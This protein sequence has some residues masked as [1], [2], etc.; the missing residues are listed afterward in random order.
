MIESDGKASKP[1]AQSAVSGALYLGLSQFLRLFFTILSTIV[2]SRLLTPDDY[3]VLASVGPVIAFITMFQDFGLSSATI[4]KHTITDVESNAL[5]W[6]NVLASIA[7]A[8]ALVAIAPVVAWFY[9]DARAGYVTA[10]GAAGVLIGGFGLQQSALLNRHMR[11]AALSVLDIVNAAV[12][13]FV[14]SALAY[15]MRS[16]WALVLA[17]LVG[18]AIQV[19]ILWRISPWQPTFRVSVSGARGAVKFGGHV[20]GFNLVNF[21]VRNA[22]N[23]LIAKFD[24]VAAVGLYDRS[25]KLMMMPLQNLNAPVTR[26]LLPM[27]SRLQDDPARYRRTFVFATRA[28]ML[29]SAPGITIA[30]ALSDR[31]MPFLLG[32]RWTAAGPIFFWL[33]L[34]GLV[35]PIA[36]MTGVLFIS[37]GRTR[38]MLHWGWISALVTLAGFAIGLHWGAVGIAASL[39]A[40]AI[41]RVP[42]LFALCASGGSVRQRDLYGAQCEPLIGC[43]LAAALAIW[44]APS[45]QMMPLLCLSMPAAYI[46]AFATSLGSSEGRR[47]ARRAG[48][49]V[50]E[51]LASGSARL[52]SANRRLV[53]KE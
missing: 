31:L 32:D 41:I 19:G 26:L 40:T 36:N 39:F 20:T 47:T 8:V 4:Q 45:F 25:Y 10:A 43:A 38:T 52:S 44:L 27:L 37:S 34:T 50:R 13:F 51:L 29:A 6:I 15:L 48:A 12:T 53:P 28:I 42:F 30:V 18:S 17:T 3:G 33:G 35:Q 16:Y 46:L 9:H 5:F 7:I 14:A 1:T 21:F 2:I 22:D 49:I 11:F 23:I 24:G